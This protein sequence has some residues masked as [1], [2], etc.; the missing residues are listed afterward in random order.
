MRITPND[1]ASINYLRN[2]TR[3]SPQ[4]ADIVIGALTANLI[5]G[6]EKTA[7]VVAVPAKNAPLLVIPKNPKRV[8]FDICCPQAG[9]QTWPFY[10]YDYPIQVVNP[11][12]TGPA[13][14]ICYLGL[15][16]RFHATSNRNQ[17]TGGTVSINDIW[18]W[19]GGGLF[20]GG[21]SWFLGFEAVI[22]A[23]GNPK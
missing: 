19:C 9:N 16:V 11:V 18:A 7:Y 10:S 21:I 6:T 3:N 13:N 8:S 2:L 17:E 15:P 23:T 4:L 20:V 1:E 5:P 12:V 22:S 14:T